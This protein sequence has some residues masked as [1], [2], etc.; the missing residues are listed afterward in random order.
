MVKAISLISGGLDSSL[1]TKIILDQGVKIEGLNLFTPFY[2]STRKYEVKKVADE[3]NIK[4]KIFDISGEYITMIEKPKYGYGRNLNPCINCRILMYKKAKEYMMKVEAS[5]IISGDVLGQRPMSQYRKAL[6]I[7]EKESGL[8]GLVLR[9]LSAKLLP[10]SIPEKEGWVNREKVLGINGRSRKPQIALAKDYKISNHASPAGG[11]LLT[12]SGF[13]RKMKD[14]MRYSEVNLYNIELLK[15]GRHFRLSHCAK[16]I[17]GRNKEIN[18]KL[19]NLARKYDIYF[20]PVEIKGPVGIG[21]GEFDEETISL[22][23]QIVARYSDG[24]SEDKVKI[25]VENSPLG[26]TDF[27]VVNRLTGKR[28]EELRI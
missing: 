14:L 24:I 4:L 2:K 13:T 18:E 8:E 26:N 5:F 12:D 3:L 16:V 11:C 10:V 17:V 9:P 1:A 28:L 22:A 7:I 25:A 20:N 23:S 27:I 6:K 21:L 15:I 19:L